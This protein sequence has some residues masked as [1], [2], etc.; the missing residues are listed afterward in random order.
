[1][2]RRIFGITRNTHK[3]NCDN[4]TCAVAWRFAL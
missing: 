1:M 2:A 4:L 3:H